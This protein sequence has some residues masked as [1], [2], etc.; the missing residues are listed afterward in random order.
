MATTTMRTPYGAQ[1]RRRRFPYGDP[2][3]KAKSSQVAQTAHLWVHD[4][5]YFFLDVKWNTDTKAIMPSITRNKTSNEPSPRPPEK[6]KYLSKKSMTSLQ[7]SG[8]QQRAAKIGR[9]SDHD[10]LSVKQSCALFNWT[11]VQRSQP[12][13]TGQACAKY[14]NDNN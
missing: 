2:L 12:V 13:I 9:K 4:S 8:Q 14:D 3:R 6:P 11:K 5:F 1:R 7:K 10:W